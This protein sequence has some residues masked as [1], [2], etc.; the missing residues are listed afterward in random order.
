MKHVIGYNESNISKISEDFWKMVE[1]AEWKKV[2]DGYIDNPIIDEK[3]KNVFKKCQFRIYDK[4]SYREIIK[5]KKEYN[6][7]YLYLLGFYQNKLDDVYPNIK[8]GYSDR[9]IDLISSIIGLG[10]NF[11]KRSLDN[12]EIFV[13]MLENDYY[14]ENFVYILDISEKEY[15]DIRIEFDPLLRDSIKYNI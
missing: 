8:I 7:V 6:I 11:V 13:R 10:K 15:W 12:P 5:F 2:I 14:A 9:H 3:H 4:F 1:V